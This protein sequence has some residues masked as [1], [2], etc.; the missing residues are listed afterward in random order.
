MK[1]LIQ[2]V[3]P[4]LRESSSAGGLATVCKFWKEAVLNTCCKKVNSDGGIVKL[5][6]KL[7][8]I[9]YNTFLGVRKVSK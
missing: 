9:S 4:F 5:V 7:F 8:F 6:L 1:F 2:E 3:H